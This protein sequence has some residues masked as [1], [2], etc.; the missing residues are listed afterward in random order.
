MRVGDSCCESGHK[1]VC[2]DRQ[3]IVASKAVHLQA[4]AAPISP[5]LRGYIYREGKKQSAEIDRVEEES[6]TGVIRKRGSNT[7]RKQRQLCKRWQGKRHIEERR[8]RGKKR[9]TS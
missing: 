5:F 6:N 1:G 8:K 9:H 2:C 4:A 3:R 7:G